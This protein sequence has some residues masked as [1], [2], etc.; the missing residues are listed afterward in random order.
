M[1]H[2]RETGSR[3][4][5]SSYVVLLS[6]THVT[7]KETVAISLSR[8]LSCPWLKADMVHTAAAFGSRSQEKKGYDYRKVFGRIWLSKIQRIGFLTSGNELDGESKVEVTGQLD[9][10]GCVGNSTA[11]CAAVISLPHMLKPARDA[12]RDIMRAHSIRTIFVVMQITKETLSGRTLGA[13]EPVLA[14]EIMEQKLAH[15]QAPLEEEKDIILVDST[16]DVDAVFLEIMEDI[17]RQ[18]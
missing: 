12:I 7:G 8:S 10:E 15:I 17:S 13:E 11:G 3:P 2:S 6:G 4:S 16:R 18:L 5:S 1:S 9:I 14:E